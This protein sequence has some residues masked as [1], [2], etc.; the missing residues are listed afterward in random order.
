VTAEKHAIQVEPWHAPSDRPNR[1]AFSYWERSWKGRAIDGFSPHTAFIEKNKWDYLNQDLRCRSGVAIEV[2]GG[3][4]HM[5]SRMAAAGFE[6]VLVD[7]SQAAL[8]CARNSWQSM[9]GRHRKRYVAADAL[10]LPFRDNSVAAVVSCGLLEHFA[11]PLAPVREMVRVL[12]PGGL[13]YADICPR[14]VSLVGALDFLYPTPKGWYEAR[15]SKKDIRGLVTEAGLDSVRL[16]AA[17]VLPPR[18][19]PGRGRFPIISRMQKW[20]I[21][22]WADFWRSM[23]GTRLAELLGLYYYISAEKPAAAASRLQTEDRQQTT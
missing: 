11:D 8:E 16:F 7:Y 19:I 2:G 18:N 14:K 20:L 10:C 4:G 22:H 21:E 23:D 13:F 1:V 5:A 9:P 15:L 17:G 12:K 6:M 3:S